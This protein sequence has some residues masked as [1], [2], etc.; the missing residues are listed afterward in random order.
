MEITPSVL[1]FISEAL[2]AILKQNG[3]N[4][5]ST[6]AGASWTGCDAVDDNIVIQV[7]IAC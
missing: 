6:E 4:I 1:L 7:F 2:S 3:P 5:I